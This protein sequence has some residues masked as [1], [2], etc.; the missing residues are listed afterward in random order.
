MFNLILA[1]LSSAMVA[2]VMRLAQPRVEN[3]TG[4]LAGNY[5][6]CALLALALSCPALGSGEWEGIPFAA[7]LGIVNGLIYLGGFAL[8]QW[9]TRHNGVVLSS[10]FMKLGI[11]VSMLISV[12]WF[13]E[14]PTALQF[15]GFILAV[16]AIVIINYRKG[17]S[18]SRGSWAL[19]VMLCMSGMGDGMSKV[20]EVYGK[21]QM[22]NIFLFFTFGAALVFCL[23]LMARKGERL[24]KKELLY[25]SLLGIPNFFSSLFLLNS[26]HSV[27]AVIAFPT[28]SVATILVVALTGILVFREK[29]ERK[30]IVG[31]A[32]ICIALVLLN[33]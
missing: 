27:P 31:A 16:A 5:I 32:L 29:L 17:T 9:S 3:P 33:L 25:G 21:A 4:L 18:L 22:Q 7:G 10:I 2:I 15:L 30:Q 26:L 13:R 11:L 19:L 6:L 28:Y 8:M 20:F 24:G 12:V 1:I 14:I 23:I